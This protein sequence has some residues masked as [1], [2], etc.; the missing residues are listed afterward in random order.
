MIEIID[1]CNRLPDNIVAVNE[2][3]D[4]STRIELSVLVFMLF[5]AAFDQ[6]YGFVGERKAFE[7][8]RDTNA[9]RSRA[10]EVAI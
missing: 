5:S 2:G 1:D 8:H 7:L 9:V 10:A 4:L 3:W 6:V